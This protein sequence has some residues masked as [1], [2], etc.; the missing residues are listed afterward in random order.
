MANQYPNGMSEGAGET[1]APLKHLG[2]YFIII[3][4]IIATLNIIIVAENSGYLGSLYFKLIN[5]ILQI[6]G[7]DKVYFYY[8]HIVF[9]S[10]VCLVAAAVIGRFFKRDANKTVY[11]C[12]AFLISGI[13]CELFIFENNLTILMS[14][15][16]AVLVS[17]Y[18]AKNGGRGYIAPIIV[19]SIPLIDYA[20]SL[21]YN[22]FFGEPIGLFKSI[23]LFSLSARMSYLP[24]ILLAL[25][26]ISLLLKRKNRTVSAKPARPPVKEAPL[27]ETC[28]RL[29]L[30]AGLFLFASYLAFNILSELSALNYKNITYSYRYLRFFIVFIPGG[31]LTVTVMKTAKYRPESEKQARGFD[32][33]RYTMIVT[34]III[35][36]ESITHLSVGNSYF[37]S[38]LPASALIFVFLEREEKRHDTWICVLAALLP[39]LILYLSDIASVSLYNLFGYVALVLKFRLFLIFGIYLAIGFFMLRNS[40]KTTSVLK[41]EKDTDDAAVVNDENNT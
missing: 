4:T 29:M 6:L 22:L 15:F 23:D 5:S 14:F 18:S 33:I 10:V 41:A 9:E 3:G 24:W 16:F 36:S 28:A 12:A 32:F 37:L 8:A 25:N 2:V 7:I 40:K 1:R 17:G 34:V 20:F 11:A 31:L 39:A 35:V 27:A 21:D 26:G 13:I 38:L 30:A 19:F